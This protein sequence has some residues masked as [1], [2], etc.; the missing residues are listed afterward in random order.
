M[1][2]LMSGTAEDVAV[3]AA[4]P[5]LTTG[6]ESTAG[7]SDAV[8]GAAGTETDAS[9]DGAGLAWTGAAGEGAGAMDGAGVFGRF[10]GLSLTFWYATIVMPL[11]R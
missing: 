11:I 3:V 1:L 7:V 5:G 6:P 8:A 4:G 9:G 2:A 10:C